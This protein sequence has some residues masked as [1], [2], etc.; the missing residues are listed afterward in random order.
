MSANIP[1]YDGMIAVLITGFSI[2]RAI[3]AAIGPVIGA[4]VYRTPEAFDSSNV[5]FGS[6]GSP[7]L[8][9]L[10]GASL[11]VSAAAALASLF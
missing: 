7:G 2:A 5:R 1:L 9:G 11:A 6:V 10:V 3:G 8:V 4:A